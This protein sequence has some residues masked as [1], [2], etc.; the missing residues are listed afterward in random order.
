MTRF[1]NR[2]AG[3]LATT[4]LATVALMP[5]PAANAEST[6]V[7]D[8]AD[9]TA[10]LSDIHR[11]TANHAVSR[12]G[13]IVTFDDLRRHNT[14]GSSGATIYLDTKPARTGPEFAL[15]T[16]LEDGTDYQ[17]MRMRNWRPFGE[18]KACDHTVGLNYTADTARFSV[19]RS[20][21]GLPAKVRVGVRMVDHH[22]GSHVITD[23]M[24]GPRRY[25]SW[26]ARG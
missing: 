18:P 6:A 10:S 1:T 2:L 23:W 8:G 4:A 7:N 9:A 12:L 26:L 19:A 11:V 17:L 13:V 22:D 24:T 15:F 5:T 16:G 21:I 25:T 3:L 20:C 14:G